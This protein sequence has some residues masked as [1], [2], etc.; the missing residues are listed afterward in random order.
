MKKI[1]L[2]CPKCSAIL[3]VDRHKEEA[4]CEYCGYR[5]LLEREDTTEEIYVKAQAKSYGYHKGRLKAEEEIKTSRRCRKIIITVIVFMILVVLALFSVFTE[6]MSK[7][8]INPF[9]YIQVSFQGKDGKGEVLIET[10]NVSEEVDINR[11]DFNISKERGL[12]EGET[13]TIQAS[14][15][16]YVLL[17]TTKTYTVEGL[18]EYLKEL[19]N[20]SEEAIELI[21]V[22]AESTLKLNLDSSKNA[23]NFIDMKPVKLFLLTDGKQKNR[24]YDVFEARFATG[25]GEKK[26]YVVAYFNDVIVRNGTQASVSMAG[27]MYMGNITQV[28]GWLHITAYD[29]LEEIRASVLSF[30]EQNMELKEKDL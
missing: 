13:I 24:L 22:H 3:K 9:D 12:S 1:D 8:K 5:M 18:D 27:G 21:H 2:T 15:D 4:V 6:E 26:L 7:V 19:E 11:V 29:S 25:S 28:Q 17:K 30:Q 14:G 20:L 10:M 23:G 16:D